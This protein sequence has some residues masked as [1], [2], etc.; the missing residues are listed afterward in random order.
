MFSNVIFKAFFLFIGMGEMWVWVWF[1]GFDI[2]IQFLNH[3]TWT[4]QE[5]DMNQ[6]YNATEITT[7]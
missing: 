1:F 2:Q 5:C 7:N 3:L 4:V 6:A